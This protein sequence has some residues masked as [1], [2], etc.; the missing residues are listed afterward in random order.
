MAKRFSLVSPVARTQSL[1]FTQSAIAG[2]RITGFT[3]A[4]AEIERWHVSQVSPD[5]CSAPAPVCASVRLN[6]VI[7]ASLTILKQGW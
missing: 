4:N 5:R 1:V 2:R 7:Q 6:S 3:Y